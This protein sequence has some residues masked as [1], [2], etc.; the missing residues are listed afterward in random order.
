[1]DMTFD[2]LLEQALQLED[3]ERLAMI[4]KLAASFRDL[5]EKS[6]EQEV[7]FTEEEITDLLTINPTMSPAEMIAA[8]LTGTWADMGIEDGAEWVN[9]QKINSKTY[10]LI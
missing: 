10:P 5:P 7:P 1:M 3:Q 8:G 9:Q 2:T 6:E 4:E